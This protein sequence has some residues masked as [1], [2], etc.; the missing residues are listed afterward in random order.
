MGRPTPAHPVT[1]SP[2]P[3][4]PARDRLSPHIRGG[5]PRDEGHPPVNAGCEALCVCVP[6]GRGHPTGGTPPPPCHVGARLCPRRRVP[7]RVG[8]RGLRDS[9]R[10]PAATAEA[11]RSHNR[12]HPPALNT[13]PPINPL[14]R[15][16]GGTPSGEDPHPTPKPDTSSAPRSSARPPNEWDGVGGWPGPP[17]QTLQGGAGGG[18]GWGGPPVLEWGVEGQ[19]LSPPPPTLLWGWRRGGGVYSS[20]P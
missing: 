16:Q 11:T 17:L 19:Q 3:G 15:V 10:R 4:T 12:C 8:A 13:P 6:R 14:C 2:A 20:P 5:H 1:A 9:P 7:Q 18:G